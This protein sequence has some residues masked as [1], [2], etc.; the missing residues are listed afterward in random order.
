MKVR[1]LDSSLEL[2]I[3]SLEKHTIA[4]ILRTIEL[5]EK[6]GHK[7]GMPHT[8]KIGKVYELRIH[9]KQEVCIFYVFRKVEIILLHGFTKKSQKTPRKELSTA[10][11]KLSTLTNI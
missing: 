8:R 3:E 2:F 4:K 11:Q 1:I 7:L 10:V 5:L 6:F 9:G